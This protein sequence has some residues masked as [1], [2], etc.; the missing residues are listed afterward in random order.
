LGYDPE[1]AP[2]TLGE[3]IQ[4]ARRRTGLTQREL[5]ERLGVDQ[6][7]VRAWEGGTVGRPYTRLRTLFEK[8]VEEAE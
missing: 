6:A 1:P 7:T 2:T 5:G 8:F 4:A 3:R